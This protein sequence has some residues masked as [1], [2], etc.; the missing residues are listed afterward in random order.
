[1]KKGDRRAQVTIF[2]II[3]I[4]LVVSVGMVFY[5]SSISNKTST[6]DISTLSASE[7]T[8]QIEAQIDKCLNEKTIFAIDANGLDKTQIQNFLSQN[9][10]ACIQ[11]TINKYN[12]VAEITPSSLSVIVNIDDEKIEIT[13]NYPISVKKTDT[14]N[15]NEFS[16]TLPRTISTNIATSPFCQTTGDYYLKS[17]D[18]KFEIFVPTGTKA[19]YKN[20]TCLDKIDIRIEDPIETYSNRATSLTSLVYIPQPL[21]AE[22]SV[23]YVNIKQKYTT[24]DY[25]DYY[26]SL[27]DI[28][29]SV[30]SEDKLKIWYY[31]KLTEN[32][33]VYP[34]PNS[35]NLTIQEMNAYVNIFYDGFLH[36]SSPEISKTTI[37]ES[38]DRRMNVL[39]PQNTIITEGG[40]NVDKVSIEIKP[41]TSNVV[42]FGMN[43]YDFS[44]SGAVME[45]NIKVS[46][47]YTQEEAERP[48]FRY[49]SYNWQNLI[50][51]T[52]QDPRM[53]KLDITSLKSEKNGNEVTFS[54]KVVNDL[55]QILNCNLY[56]NNTLVE[57]KT[58]QNGTIGTFIRTLNNGQYSW[59]IGC[60]DS[61]GEEKSAIQEVNVGNS[62]IPALILPLTNLARQTGHAITGFAT[63]NPSRSGLNAR[64]ES[65]LK[66][67]WYD[68]GVYRPWPTSVDEEKKIVTGLVSHFSEL[69]TAQGCEDFGYGKFI[70]V[71]KVEL[72]GD[73]C[74]GESKPSVP[75]T[76]SIK[77]ENSCATKE[78]SILILSKAS[79]GDT[80]TLEWTDKQATIG[81]HT[82]GVALVD[83]NKALSNREGSCA[84]ADAYMRVKGIGVETDWSNIASN[85]NE[86]TWKNETGLLGWDLALCA[87]Y[88]AEKQE[89]CAVCVRFSEECIRDSCGRLGVP[90]DTMQDLARCTEIMYGEQCS[91]NAAE[92]SGFSDYCKNSACNKC[93]EWC[94]E[95]PEGFGS[96][97]TT[98]GSLEHC[99][100]VIEH[101]C[102]APGQTCDAS[103]NLNDSEDY[104]RGNC[105]EMGGTYNRTTEQ[106]LGYGLV[107]YWLDLSNAEVIAFA[108][109]LAVN[110]LT[111][112]Y[113]EYFGMDV[114]VG[115][116][117]I[118][119][120]PQNGYAKAKFLVETMRARNITTFINYVNWNAP[121]I[122]TNN[123]F[124]DAWFQ[125]GLGGLI[126]QIGTDHVIMQTAVE[127]GEQC[128]DKFHKW[129]KWMDLNWNGMKSYSIS[130]S[131]KNSPGPEWFISPSP[132]APNG[133]FATGAIVTTDDGTT[134][135]YFADREGQGNADPTKLENYAGGINIPCH[136]GFIYY[137][138][139]YDGKKPDIGAIRAL[140]RVAAHKPTPTPATPATIIVTSPNASQ[141]YR[142][143]SIPISGTAN[144]NIIR[145]A[146]KINGGSLINF[147]L[148][149][150][151]TAREG[152][153]L[154]E[155][156][157]ENQQGI[158]SNVNVTFRVN[159]TNE[160]LPTITIITPASDGYY[161]ASVF[162]NKTLLNVSSNQIIASWKYSLNGGVN[163]LSV[164]N[165][166][167]FVNNGENNLIVYGT[168]ANGTGSASAKFNVLLF[169]P[170][171]LPRITISIPSLA[172]TYTSN[173]IY[174]QVSANQTIDYWKYSLNGEERKDCNS[175]NS[176][177]FLEASDGRNNLTIFGTNA[178]GTGSASTYFFVNTTSA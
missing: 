145:A 164:I 1:M 26:N 137:D 63:T 135:R 124:T 65:D 8:N 114:H 23:N 58:V 129:N 147:S 123:P 24:K 111:A 146:Y 157:A 57:S 140:G 53:Y 127:C 148:P 110:N 35:V 6:I 34:S 80:G 62:G 66:M 173:Q 38:F 156:Y 64:E 128:T 121:D 73:N 113:I 81:S 94:T 172:V 139:G 12:G 122:C 154:F 177:N 20:G 42:N 107:R 149:H 77:N 125:N 43:D 55:V 143:L 169:N 54:F 19:Q 84:W 46:Y 118:I 9:L 39:I 142:T 2:I 150:S 22:F 82:F 174:V 59:Q 70:D 72:S 3:G 120:K 11:P 160:N 153:N 79:E 161:E 90:G 158:I 168:N 31:D 47:K 18:E 171:Y 29:K 163:N 75:V 86:T 98:S 103:P 60:S 69:I 165:N 7:I 152:E 48:E 97:G 175:C 105:Q 178:N 141:V 85:M 108:D 17:W 99:A 51:G 74:T 106:F 16:L 14:Q 28:T 30:M 67:A 166:Q 88:P 138:F 71:N 49:G 4:L 136:S 155:L 92:C 117:N 78:D 132:D 112:T 170:A 89:A 126:Q 101:E 95:M 61:V 159:L 151:I 56:I 133:A 162:L 33:Y 87:S 93:M 100:D 36:H 10:A 37:I 119:N 45:P 41:K 5:F 104:T 15:L 91:W 13:G 40:N 27:S 44:P 131:V 68:E 115:R 130:G 50:N 32:F 116:Y 134:L 83:S 109:Q 76:Y 25:T 144:Q 167:I 96:T 52:W 21:G 102:C 176:Q